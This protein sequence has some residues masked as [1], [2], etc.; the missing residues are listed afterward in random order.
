MASTATA[1]G[2][3]PS[4]SPMVT[5]GSASSPADA[6]SSSPLALSTNPNLS[7]GAVAGVVSMAGSVFK[8][9]KHVAFWDVDGPGVDAW[10]GTIPGPFQHNGTGN[11]A[12]GSENDNSA[13]DGAATTAASAT[14]TTPKEGT[15][16][17]TMT[18]LYPAVFLLYREKQ[19]PVFV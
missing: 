3:L 2:A 11:P 12:G 9:K 14:T 17:S 7:Q 8:K 13:K 4:S 10:I 15:Y 1:K 19:L 5:G 18:R 16:D 6:A